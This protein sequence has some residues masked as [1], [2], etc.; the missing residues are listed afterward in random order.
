MSAKQLY[1]VRHGQTAFNVAKRL[2]GQC[3]SDLTELG[4]KQAQMMG[5]SLAQQSNI[6]SFTIVASPLGRALQ[7]AT[8]IA[9][10]LHR[11]VHSITQEPRL[12]EFSLGDWEG[13]A[14]PE[15]KAEHPEFYQQNDWYLN[16][17]HA[18]SLAQVKHRLQTWLADP[19]TPEQVIAVSHALTGSVLRALVTGLSDQGVFEQP[20]PQDGYFYFD[21]HQ[22]T[23]IDC[24]ALLAK[25]AL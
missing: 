7:T 25:S 16:A 9:K 22:L 19:Q 8:W 20:R 6:A 10:A 23:Y 18:E 14:A 5:H 15:I 1:I 13:M 3:N 4:E 12:M 2:Q 24:S 17:P 11:D 21:S